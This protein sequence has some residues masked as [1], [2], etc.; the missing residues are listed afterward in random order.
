MIT[1]EMVVP[2]DSTLSLLTKGAIK[3]MVTG[4]AT[5]PSSSP[6]L[7][8]N[9]TSTG[10][11]FTVLTYPCTVLSLS[12]PDDIIS[13][14]RKDVYIYD[15]EHYLRVRILD[16][17]SLD[18][19]FA[20]Y[21]NAP[22]TYRDHMKSSCVLIRIKSYVTSLANTNQDEP[23]LCLTD[24]EVCEHKLIK[25]N[26]VP[27][28]VLHQPTLVTSHFNFIPPGT[29]FNIKQGRIFGG[30]VV[31]FLTN[32]A[33]FMSFDALSGCQE[34]PTPIYPSQTLLWSREQKRKRMKV[35]IVR[36]GGGSNRDRLDA[37]YDEITDKLDIIARF[38]SRYQ[39]LSSLATL[40]QK[41]QNETLAQLPSSISLQMSTI[42]A[43]RKSQLERH[44]ASITANRGR[45][46]P[47]STTT[48]IIEQHQDTL[49]EIYDRQIP[50]INQSTDLHID[51]LHYCHSKL[52][53]NLMPEAG[54]FRT[55]TVRVSTTNFVYDGQM[56]DIVSRLM[57]SLQNLRTRLIYLNQDTAITKNAASASL[58]N[59][60]S[61]ARTSFLGTSNQ[62]GQ[63]S[64]NRTPEQ[65]R[66]LA[67]L[68]YAAAA[69]MGI[70]DTH[71]YLDGNGRLARI[72]L[73]FV[74]Y[75]ELQLPFSVPLFATPEQRVEYTEIICK[76]RQNIA[77]LAVGF[78]NDDALIEAYESCGALQ[79][80]IYLILDRIYKSVIECNNQIATKISLHSED[81]DSRTAR[82]VR[83]RV[84]T[85]DSCPICFESPPNM[86]TL[87]C[88]TAY[89]VKCLTQWLKTNGKC[90]HCRFEIPCI[91]ETTNL[92]SDMRRI[93]NFFTDIIPSDF[94]EYADDTLQYGLRNIMEGH[95]TYETADDSAA[96]NTEQNGNEDDADEHD[97]DASNTEQNGGVQHG[98]DEHDTDHHDTTTSD[99][100]VEILP[101]ECQYCNNRSARDC[102]NNSCA[103]CCREYG[104]YCTRHSTY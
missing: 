93:V 42:E 83:E 24:I 23:I 56:Q 17:N 34:T 41:E 55:K 36:A 62:N 103:R 61:T 101:P 66:V 8:T 60:A 91:D 84:L 77:L 54:K 29:S 21:D 39:A 81:L 57:L 15:G 86:S 18:D 35:D 50:L 31:D 89:H 79:P 95:S 45:S 12:P 3:A 38:L 100:I 78:V 104:G 53:Q 30:K 71:P 11:F 20:D 52:C 9:T 102:S 97:T 63:R 87:C 76:T 58:S 82:N 46:E 48:T 44:K 28:Q 4:D 67:T 80:M 33:P 73:N 43:F 10:I 40:S 96:S 94:H 16:K 49:Q 88:G 64:N 25:A 47:T 75:H 51:M 59:G 74:L 65:R 1:S 85:T 14:T 92:S 32:I 22:N 7:K 19:R 13:T 6:R 98:A 70:L 37:N 72:V 27:N 2:P 68:T 90:P 99:T 69:C 5:L 26:A